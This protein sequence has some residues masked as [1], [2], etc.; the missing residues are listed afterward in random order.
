MK[1]VKR[2]MLRKNEN[3]LISMDKIQVF[4]RKLKL[5]IQIMFATVRPHADKTLQ[6]KFKSILESAHNFDWVREPS[7]ANLK[8]VPISIRGE[9]TDL[10]ENRS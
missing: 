9:V 2:K 7:V 6:Q 4:V 8:H 1:E 10:K 3:I 5:L